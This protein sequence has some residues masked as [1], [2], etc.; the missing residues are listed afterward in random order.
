MAAAAGTHPELLRRPRLTRL[1]VAQIHL[2]A[3]PLTTELET[4]VRHARDCN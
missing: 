3:T 2:L 4:D 1:R